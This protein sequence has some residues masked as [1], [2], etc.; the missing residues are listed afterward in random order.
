MSSI[1]LKHSGGN[2]VSLNPPTSAPT[3]SEVAFKL[4]QSD[5]SANQVLQT[6]GNGNLSWVS[7]PT[8][9][10]SM[11]DMWH[12]SSETSF[13]SETAITSWA[14]TIDSAVTGAGNLGSSMSN[15]GQYFT[16]PETG[17]YEIE[18]Q[19]LVSVSAAESRYVASYIYSTTDGSNYARRAR[20]Y[21]AVHQDS[22][23]TTFSFGAKYIF[24]VTN[25]STHK[26][27]FANLS[28][29]SAWI[30]DIY[31]NAIYSYALFKKLGDT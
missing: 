26:V 3:S 31:S 7:L 22:S 28:E 12:V 21:G 19:S 16:F 15:S 2:S 8:G 25:T 13:Q 18:Y 9:G 11:V 27:Y 30:D 24:D 20:G 29:A 6:D 23:Q 10:L 4:P 14:R 17:I 1:K 5:G